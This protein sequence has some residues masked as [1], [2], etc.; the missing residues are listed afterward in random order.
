[1][2]STEHDGHS[3]KKLKDS[4]REPIDNVTK[5]VKKIEKEILPAIHV[6][7]KCTEKDKWNKT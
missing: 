5:R 6:E 4:L 7:L 3:F 1:M 2:T